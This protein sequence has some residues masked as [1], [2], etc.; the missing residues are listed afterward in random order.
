MGNRHIGI[1]AQELQ[2]II[3]EVVNE[4]HDGKYLGVDYASL[5]PL[6]IEAIHDL[7]ELII[8]N[9][10]IIDNKNDYIMK[11]LNYLRNNTNKLETTLNNTESK[12]SKM[13]KHMKAVRAA[14]SVS[15]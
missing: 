11:L 14:R 10:I 6:I 1:I 7:N 3:P 8:A 9:D 13:K 4:I 2:Q 5:M 12:I 15:K